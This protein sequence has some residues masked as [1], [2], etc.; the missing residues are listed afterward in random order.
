MLGKLWAPEM[1]SHPYIYTRYPVKSTGASFLTFQEI[2]T[3][4]EYGYLQ[5]NFKIEILVNFEVQAV[6]NLLINCSQNSWHSQLKLKCK[7]KT[8]YI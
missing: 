4:R 6:S 1:T 3:D 2:K 7:S 5:M 8:I